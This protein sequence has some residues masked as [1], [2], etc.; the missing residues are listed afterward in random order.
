M[1]LTVRCKVD[2]RKCKV[3]DSIRVNGDHRQ[4]KSLFEISQ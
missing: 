1:L 2:L 4:W 3:K